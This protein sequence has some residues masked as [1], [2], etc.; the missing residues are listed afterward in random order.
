MLDYARAVCYRLL[1]AAASS[2]ATARSG[3]IYYCVPHFM[4]S[5]RFVFT[6]MLRFVSGPAASTHATA[7]RFRPGFRA[8]AR[9]GGAAAL[10]M[11]TWC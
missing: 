5:R 10:A 2:G 6:S 11:L 4:V 8:A 9:L 7:A 1:R 3:P